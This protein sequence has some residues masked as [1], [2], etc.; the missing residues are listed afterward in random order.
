MKLC[1]VPRHSLCGTWGHLK[2]EEYSIIGCPVL[3]QNEQYERNKIEFNFCLLLDKNVGTEVSGYYSNLVSRVAGFLST[4]E[5]NHRIISNP[6]KRIQLED[7][8]NSLYS[9]IIESKS[10][11]FRYFDL[12]FSFDHKYTRNKNQWRWWFIRFSKSLPLIIKNIDGDEFTRV[13][14]QNYLYFQI[15]ALIDGVRNISEIYSVLTKN[16]KF[17]Y[18]TF[19]VLIRF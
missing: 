1:F 15:I 3:I 13:Y 9:K 4:L 10:F 11:V 6:E 2:F 17:V 18:G 14:E 8:L 16:L 7:V 5:T 19:Y 12:V